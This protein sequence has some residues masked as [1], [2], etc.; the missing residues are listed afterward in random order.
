MRR[1]RVLCLMHDYLVPPEDDS[2]YDISVPWKTEFDVKNTLEVMGHEVRVVGVADDLAVMRTATKDFAPHIVFNLMENF[3]EVGVFD[4]NIVS[5]LELLKVPYTGCNPRGLMLSRDKALSK[6]LL[7]Y[8]RIPVPDF[9]VFRV[10]RPVQRPK[11]LTFPLIV[12]SLTQE[13][14]IGISQASV[15]E[16]DEK[17]RERVHFIHRSV[18]TDAIVERYIPGRELYVGIV[19]NLALKVFP[20][21]ELNLGNLPRE[22]WRIATERVKWSGPYQEK[23]GI[24]S[25]PAL[26]LDDGVAERIQRLCKRVYRTLD[27]SGYARIDLRLT[28]DGRVYVLEANANPQIAY[29]EDFAEVGR[30]RRA[31]LRPAAAAH[32]QLRPRL[33]PRTP[34]VGRGRTLGEASPAGGPLLTVATGGRDTALCDT[35]G[36]EPHA[37]PSR[38]PLA[39][40][41]RTCWCTSASWR[42]A[43]FAPGLMAATPLAGLPLS[44][45]YGLLLIGLAFVLA[46]LYVRVAR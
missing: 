9:T 38:R 36:A 35:V 34:R 19:G 23:H 44:L 11:R 40:R 10:G 16:S 39:L 28:D 46:A 18:G 2:K 32:H 41:P 29:G 27:L 25:G 33:A 15:V 12:K 37:H 45:L 8:H 5:Y 42:L 7:S 31:R 24:M 43:A 30:G 22:N 6:Q 1:L 3:T 13:A 26:G 20:V 4:Q 14:S 21:W 17:L